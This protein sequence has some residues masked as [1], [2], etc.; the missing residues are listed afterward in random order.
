MAYI[1]AQSLEEALVALGASEMSV[2]AGGTDWYPALGERPPPQ[3]ILDISRIE[4]LR[5][6]T[7]EGAGWRIGAATKWS[8]LYRM[9]LPA[10]FD[11]LIAAAREVG[12]IQIQNA[13]TIAGNLCNASP[14]ADGVPPLLTLNAA[15][16]LSS[17]KGQR[18]V[19]LDR[20]IQGPR[21]TALEA[22]ELVTAILVPEI[23]GSAK[24]SFL[25]LGTRKYLVIS[26]AMVSVLLVCEEGR[27]AEAR[28]AVGACSAVAQRLPALEAELVGCDLVGL[29]NAV[30]PEHMAVLAP[31]GD[32]R[33]SAE[34]RMSAARDLITRGLIAAW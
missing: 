23:P 28:V 29:S 30:S 31:I 26:I 22:G 15:V 3:N 21:A 16:E 4:S 8:D 18:V 34:Y 14:A 10:G 9:D 17:A 13:G 12:S 6:I 25:K 20:F 2:I 27:V 33:G 19:D 24:S 1:A 11:G 32:V 5:G 7:R